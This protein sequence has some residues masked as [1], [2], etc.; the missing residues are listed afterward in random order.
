MSR[1]VVMPP[2]SP[3]DLLL[4]AYDYEL[5][6]A[7]I[8][9]QPPEIRGK[10]RLLTLN[11]ASGTLSHGR[12]DEI[13]QRLRPGD[14][15][16]LNDTRVIPA[17]LKG[18]RPSGGAVELLLL[19]NRGVTV[20]KRYPHAEL[21][22]A[23]G[24]PS[25][26]LKIEQPLSL[27]G[28]GLESLEE[29]GTGVRES[30]LLAFPLER[31]GEGW[32]LRLEAPQPVGE[33]IEAFGEL[34]LPS[35]IHRSGEADARLDRERYQTVFAREPGSAAAP[36]AG[37]HFTPALLEELRQ[38]GVE[39]RFVTL[40][41]GPGTFSPVRTDQISAHRMHAEYWQMPSDTWQAIVSAR[42]EGRRIVAVGTTSVRTLESAAQ[43][44]L[45]AAP[46][47]EPSATPGTTLTPAMLA[48]LP[49][50][51]GGE[52]SIFIYPGF[53]FKLVDAIIT[54]FHLPRSSLIM[55]VSAF[56]GR[57]RT[58]QAYAEAVSQGYRF[59][60]YGDAMFIG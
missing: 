58:L 15:L 52:T 7:Q 44:L 10:S 40:H 35:Y 16:I 38:S 12:F 1:E 53:E 8:A 34:P 32:L 55:L 60:S 22:E 17:R 49:A 13:G 31:R 48:S 54:N 47:V 51:M 30:G 56:A 9:Q 23:I 14:L 20:G 36:T 37:L 3:T 42:Q 46:P 21:W 50:P 26:R 43:Q 24:K 59:F 45:T 2:V 18:H 19:R 27:G 41:V 29:A 25:S 28:A 4:S 6:E 5:P 39:V 57:E 11:R 33:A